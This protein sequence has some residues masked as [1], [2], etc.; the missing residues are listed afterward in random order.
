[1]TPLEE[2]FAELSAKLQQGSRASRVVS[3]ET[4]FQA[5]NLENRKLVHALAGKLVAPESRFENLAALLTLD[6]YA[7]QGRSCL[8]LAEH[9]TNFDIPNL[10]LLLE[11]LG[12]KFVE[13]SNRII[14]IAGVKLNEEC[15]FV[16]AFAESY[17]RLLTYPPRSMDVLRQ[18]PEANAAEIIRARAINRAALLQMVRLKQSG[19]MILV[20][21]AGTRHRPGVEHTKRGLKEIDTYMKSFDHVLFL[22]MAGNTLR[23]NPAGENMGEDIPVKDAVVFVASEV[24][25]ASEFRCSVAPVTSPDDDQKQAVADAVMAKLDELHVLAEAVREECIGMHIA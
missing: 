19:H 7:R 16:R 21:P 13:I 1:M 14:P 24:Y 9:Y 10:F 20:Y 15:S 6:A 12:P 17:S 25:T 4:V 3:P 8:I 18:D 2:M 11:R 23:I 22:G 5:A